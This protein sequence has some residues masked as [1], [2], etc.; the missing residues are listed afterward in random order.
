[1]RNE[2]KRYFSER[3]GR[4][5]KAQPVPFEQLRRLVINVFDNFR[6]RGYM[7]EAFGYECVDGDSEGTLGHDPDAYFMRTIM[8]DG[9]WPYWEP[10]TEPRSDSLPPNWHSWDEDTLFD[11]T[12]VMH[13]LVS[14]PDDGH[15][16]AFSNCGWHYYSFKRVSG[17]EEFREEINRVVRLGD[18]AYEMDGFGQIIERVPDEFRQLV[19]APVPEGTEHDLITS[20]IDAAVRAFRT[21]GASLD[22]RRHAVRDLADVLEAL[23]SDVKDHMLPAD[24]GAL[25]N[26][27][28][29]FAIR[30]NRRDQRGDYDR[31]VWLRWA[32]Y[33]YLSTVHAV[34]RVRNR[35]RS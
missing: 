17:Q 3:H 6:E 32:F 27:A 20:R 7:Q 4:G 11:V 9:I 33:V 5:P 23:R 29:G 30:H 21:R 25:F 16:H 2:P 22:D 26:L 13:D 10:Y 31:A 35:Q 19:S 1:M 14:E 24:E 15:Y 28:N 18:P 8:R 12:E 34:L